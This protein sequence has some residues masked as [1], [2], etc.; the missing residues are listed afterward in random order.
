MLTRLSFGI[1]L[2]KL[3]ILI[4]YHRVFDTRIVRILVKIVLAANLV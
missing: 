3:S 4:M 1:G 2:V